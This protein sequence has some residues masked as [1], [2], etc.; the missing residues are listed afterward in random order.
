MP[1]PI[2]RQSANGAMMQGATS[3]FIK[4]FRTEDAETFWAAF[5][6]CSVFYPT[7]SSSICFSLASEAIELVCWFETISEFESCLT[8]AAI[9]M[10]GMMTI[11]SM[12]GPE[13]FATEMGR[14]LFLSAVFLWVGLNTQTL[15]SNQT[16]PGNSQV[17]T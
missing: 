5:D 11:L 7:V 16:E 2:A 1:N 8:R 15:L 6:C 3:A 9:H 4:Q 12:R 13:Q 10:A 17:D 14:R